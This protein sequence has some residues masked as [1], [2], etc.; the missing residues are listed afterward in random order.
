MLPG[1]QL[2]LACQFPL[3]TQAFLGPRKRHHISEPAADTGFLLSDVGGTGGGEDGAGEGGGG[4]RSGEGEQKVKRERGTE[5]EE[6]KGAWNT[7][8]TLGRG[9]RG[10]EWD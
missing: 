1:D 7:V 4:G 3:S 9:H 2:L 5:G 10:R 8:E 6:G